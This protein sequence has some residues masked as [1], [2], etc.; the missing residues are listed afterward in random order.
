VSTSNHLA[1]QLFG[2]Q[3]SMGALEAMASGI[4]EGI[5]GFVDGVGK[6]YDIAQSS[7][8]INHM[9][10][11]GT[12][13]LAAALFSPAHSAFVMYPRGGREDH[14]IH[15]PKESGEQAQDGQGQHQDTNSQQQERG[16]RHM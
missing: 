9:A 4:K 12:H 5:K 11:M 1:E 14:G 6:A 2:N 15:G 7:P 10:S 16:G 8:E 13:E 3:Q